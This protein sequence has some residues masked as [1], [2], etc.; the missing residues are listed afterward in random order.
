MSCSL[1]LGGS[2]NKIKLTPKEKKRNSEM[3]KGKTEKGERGGRRE[4]T[5]G[6]RW[7]KE[8]RDNKKKINLEHTNF[9]QHIHL[10]FDIFMAAAAAALCSLDI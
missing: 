3:L 5:K 10:I 1:V 7:E 6:K 2:E 4:R 9:I 8:K